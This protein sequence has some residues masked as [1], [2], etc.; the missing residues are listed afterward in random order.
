MDFSRLSS[1][2][3]DN[4]LTQDT[5]GKIIG[6]KRYTVSKWETGTIVISLINLNNYANY[7][8]VS[9][10]YLLKLSNDKFGSKNIG[11]LNKEL[12]GQ[13]L[14]QIRLENKLTQRDLAKLLNTTHSTIYAYEK[15]KT[16][17]LTSFAYQICKTYNISLD[18][19]C[20]RKA[21]NNTYIKE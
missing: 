11:K 5:L 20:G 8:N 7:F 18:Y 19:L 15:G 17:I 1:L 10:D 2:R 13:R 6:C 16:M 14:K 4:D 9:M 21:E 3:E 12:I